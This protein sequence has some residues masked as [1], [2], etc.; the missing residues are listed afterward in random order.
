MKSIENINAVNA[1]CDGCGCAAFAPSV[2]YTMGP[3]SITFT[4]ATTFDSGD[5]LRRLRCEVTDGDGKLNSF[6]MSG[7]GSG[8]TAGTVTFAA[9]AVTG[10]PVSAGG[11]GYTVPPRVTLAGGGGTGAVAQA[12]VNTAGVV[13]SVV[14]INGGTGYSSAPTATFVTNICEV[15]LSGTGY[16]TLRPA[17]GLKIKAFVLSTGGCKADMGTDTRVAYSNGATAT[18]GNI[19]EQGDNN[20]SGNN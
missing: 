9:G 3:N 4:Q 17:A 6:I 2:T 11:T 14:I 7:A 5:S 1:L 10:V 13:T 15:P 19:N 20:E 18:L 8:A 16:N 12:V